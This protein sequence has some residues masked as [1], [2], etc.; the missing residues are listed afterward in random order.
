MR[1][2]GVLVVGL[3]F[4]VSLT[5]LAQSGALAKNK[6]QT[7]DTVTTET[8]TTTTTTEVTGKTKPPEGYEKGQKKGWG[9]GQTPP[10]WE[11]GQK[12]GWGEGQTPPGWNKMDQNQQNQWRKDRQNAHTEI[13]E[14]T[15]RY[16]ISKQKRNEI[17]AAF[18]DAI[19][20]GMI[21]ND[22][23]GRLV[24][25]LNNKKQRRNLMVDTTQA[26][27]ELLRE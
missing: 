13:Q 25:A 19:A 2:A 9:E 17:L 24:S 6:L 21:I 16:N 27:A 15:I 7:G 23:K 12:K 26:V 3:V 18:D 11:K 10:G 14:V 20:G 4:L 22:A 5:L 8:T 1:K